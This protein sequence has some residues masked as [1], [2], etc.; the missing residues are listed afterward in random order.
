MIDENLAHH[1]Q[2][3][4]SLLG[5]LIHD[6]DV[7]SFF[8]TFI[9]HMQNAGYLPSLRTLQL[10]RSWPRYLDATYTDLEKYCASERPNLLI[11]SSE[12]NFEDE[13][14]SDESNYNVSE[15]S[16]M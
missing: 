1:L 8:L 13:G 15:N 12:R 4:P 9:D 3:C 11:F 14:I 7:E 5:L 10:D 2:D 16:K 6:C